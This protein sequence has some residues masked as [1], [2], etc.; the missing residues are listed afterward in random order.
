MNQKPNIAVIILAYNEAI[1]LPR[2]LDYIREFAREVFV[3]DSFSTDNTVELAKAGGAKVLQHSFQNYAR[4]PEWGQG[5]RMPRSP[6]N[7]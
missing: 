2:A 5:S 3:I 7:G 6:Q 1:H 4:Q